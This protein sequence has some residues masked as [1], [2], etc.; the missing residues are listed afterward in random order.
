MATVAARLQR[1]S[2]SEVTDWRRFGIAAGLTC[3]AIAGAMVLVGFRAAGPVAA[4]WFDEAAQAVA[5]FAAGGSCFALSRRSTGKV[6]TAWGL[7]GMSALVTALV[8]VSV[9]VIGTWVSPAVRFPSVAD[10]FYLA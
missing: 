10:G 2:R 7:I 3:I 6:R 1:A 4:G 5:A 9:F 8:G